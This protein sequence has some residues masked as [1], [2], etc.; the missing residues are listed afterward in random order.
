MRKCLACKS[1]L[2]LSL[3]CA[4]EYVCLFVLAF[5]PERP[6]HIGMAPKAGRYNREVLLG[7]ATRSVDEALRGLGNGVERLTC[8]YL[9][10]A[11]DGGYNVT[12][13]PKFD[14]ELAYEWE[15]RA[16]AYRESLVTLVRANHAV[17]R[18]IPFPEAWV[19]A[20]RCLTL[21]AIAKA[22]EDKVCQD[23][24]TLSEV[25]CEVLGRPRRIPAGASVGKLVA[26]SHP[27][28]PSRTLSHPPRTLDTLSTPSQHPQAPL[29]ILST[30]SQHLLDTLSTPS[31]PLRKRR[32]FQDG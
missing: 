19:T 6:C 22:S 23:E 21:D 25:R 26:L 16:E 2:S 11:E 10:F 9:G 12:A 30:P 15:L 3:S 7:L 5:R 20:L 4:C 27:P 24:K 14:S 29:N 31:W 13:T 18:M 28:A 17:R 32:T 8:K 1:L